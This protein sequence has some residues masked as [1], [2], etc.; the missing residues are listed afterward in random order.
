MK[1]L[2]LLFCVWITAYALDDSDFVYHDYED[3]QSYLEGI[4]AR[5]PNITTV[6]KIG[7]SHGNKSLWGI[8]ITDNPGVHEILEPEFRYIG[9][10]HGNEMVGREI[11][12]YL[13]KYLCEE[14]YSNN[15]SIIQL[16]NNTRIFILPSMNPDGFETAKAD[17]AD[18]GGAS[19]GSV[20]RYNQNGIDLNRDFPDHIHG[21]NTY[22]DAQPETK[23]I[24]DW[25]KE[26][27]VVLSANL[28]G[29]A[30]LVSYPLDSKWNGS[31]ETSYKDVFQRLALIY[32]K[33]HPTMHMGD[34][35]REYFENGITNGA[36]WYEI[37]GSLQDYSLW[38]KQN[39]E[40]T[41]ELSC[42]KFPAEPELKGFWQDNVNSMIAYIEQIHLGVTGVVHDE[43]N[44]TLSG[45]KVM[46]KGREEF[47]F[48]TTKGGEFWIL[49]NPGKYTIVFESP[50]YIDKEID[51][52]LGEEEKK[53]MDVPLV[54]GVATKETISLCL[55][56]MCAVVMLLL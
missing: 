46:V 24:I 26:T 16:I 52:T 56:I 8:E 4:H 34:T 49:L 31:G 33:N 48:R 23:A 53:V 38:N 32:S 44:T 39:F 19:I 50:Y 28:H 11:L 41:I 29:G 2:S 21:S 51:V 18:S 3:L 37:Y 25:I 30:L 7:A 55:L 42:D 12:L 9:N 1:Y 22:A 54:L 17:G 35:C 40:V 13:A 36:A 43:A 45:I 20:G 6:L 15:A 5:Y 27:N 10:M 14:Y 47:V